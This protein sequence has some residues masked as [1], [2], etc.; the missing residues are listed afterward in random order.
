MI[1]VLEVQPLITAI[2]A[3]TAV[4]PVS[5][6]PAPQIWRAGAGMDPHSYGPTCPIMLTAA[7]M[8]ISRRLT[9]C[10]DDHPI[11]TLHARG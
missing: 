2:R 9:L 4:S 1:Q 6:I 8:P 3:L 5:L 10:I 7:A 11:A